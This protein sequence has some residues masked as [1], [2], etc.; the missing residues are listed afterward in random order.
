DRLLYV[1]MFELS[2]TVNI[3]ESDNMEN[4]FDIES[5]NANNY[6][7][8]FDLG[9]LKNFFNI[10]FSNMDNFSNT[11]DLS[12]LVNC[13]NVLDYDNLET[14]FDD[15][16]GNTDKYTFDSDDSGNFFNS[17][18]PD[19]LEAYL[20]AFGPSNIEAFLNTFDP[21]SPV[22]FVERTDNEKD[23]DFDK[24]V[25]NHGTECGF[26]FTITHS[27]KD[28]ENRILWCC[29]YKYMKGRS[30]ISKKEAHI[31]NDRDS[32]YYTT[33]YTFYVN[34]YRHKKNN[35]FYVSKIDEMSDKVK[36]LTSCRC[37]KEEI[38]DASSLY[39]KLIKKQQADPTF[40]ID[41][42]FEDI[43]S[44]QHV[45]SYNAKIKNCVNRLLSVLELEQSVKKL[46][47][48]ESHF[49]YLNETITILKLQRNKINHSIY[50]WYHIVN[51]ENE[52]EQQVVNELQIGMF[53]EDM[54]KM[55]IIE[56]N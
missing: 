56:L 11:P 2:N 22:T 3:Y 51:L 17:F 44:T 43:Q 53:S 38:S 12:S 33:G 14:F 10:E 49:V 15:K 18:D 45:E 16:S 1:D 32:S 39:L 9:T 37:K 54:F 41:T 31:I 4:F 27:K 42:Q 21:N 47:E 24:W 50:Y 13:S 7:S 6:S 19:N 36:F 34:M 35:L 20:N 30:Y 23:N 28:K 55:S 29:T 46:L 8:T 25:N 52:L 26:A 40:H 48:K 5:S